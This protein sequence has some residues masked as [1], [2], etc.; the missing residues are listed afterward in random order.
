[1]GKDVDQK[2]QTLPRGGA[3]R[4]CLL[5]HHQREFQLGRFLL[6]TRRKFC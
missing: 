3:N 6:G 4:G 2:E 5:A 1:M